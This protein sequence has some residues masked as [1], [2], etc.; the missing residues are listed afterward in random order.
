MKKWGGDKRGGTSSVNQCESVSTTLNSRWVF[1]QDCTKLN[2]LSR[3]GI[4]RTQIVQGSKGEKRHNAKGTHLNQFISFI[5]SHYPVPTNSASNK[6]A[7]RA[8]ARAK[9]AGKYTRKVR[10]LDHKSTA[11]SSPIGWL[12]STTPQPGARSR[13]AW[14][15]WWNRLEH[16]FPWASVTMA[17]SLWRV[18]RHNQ[19]FWR[20]WARQKHVT[21][22]GIHVVKVEQAVGELH[23]APG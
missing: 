9:V 10:K 14:T 23:G 12:T 3:I 4:K 20:S 19:I 15:A 2:P 18:R 17:R 13:G 6:Q 8:V 5:K 21:V 7:T 16:S 22:G 1:L 11:D